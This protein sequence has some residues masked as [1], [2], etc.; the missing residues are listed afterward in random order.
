M[1]SR[2]DIFRLD[3]SH[4]YSVVKAEKQTDMLGY[5]YDTSEKNGRAYV[6]HRPSI[7]PQQRPPKLERWDELPAYE[8][9]HEMESP[10]KW[11]IYANGDDYMPLGLGGPVPDE[12]RKALEKDILLTSVQRGIA[13]TSKSDVTP[14]YTEKTVMVIVTLIILVTLFIGFIAIEQYI[15]RNDGDNAPAAATETIDPAL[16]GGIGGGDEIN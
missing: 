13:D 6:L 11:L 9:P 10:R 7:L 1:G 12:E 8:P 15:G 2:V 14:K 16:L 4:S 5:V 3:Q